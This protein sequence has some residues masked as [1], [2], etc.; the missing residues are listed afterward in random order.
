M[1]PV[2]W[3]RLQHSNSRRRNPDV[4]AALLRLGGKLAGS[5][6]NNWAREWLVVNVLD[7]SPGELRMLDSKAQ[8]YLQV[9]V[10]GQGFNVSLFQLQRRA[11]PPS[12]FPFSLCA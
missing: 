1:I 9:R 6:D 5:I 12:Q 10:R 11:D 4:R 7:K 2:H 3:T 8:L